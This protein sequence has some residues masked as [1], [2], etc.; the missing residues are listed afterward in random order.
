MRKTIAVD[1]DGTLC[2]N[3]WPGIGEPNTA[4][5]GQ[6]IEEQ[7]NGAAIVLFTCRNKKGLR[8][9]VNWCKKQ[10]LIFDEVNKNT[11]ERIKLYKEDG[12]K[13]SADIYID[14]RA[15]VFTFGEKLELNG[16]TIKQTEDGGSE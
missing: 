1:F 4:L 15:A 5:I 10:G 14:D 7:K 9:A 13:I 6:L 12:R 8:E 2:T 16:K 3:K 11:R